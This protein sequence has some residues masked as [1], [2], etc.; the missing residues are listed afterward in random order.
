MVKMKCLVQKGCNFIA[1]AMD[2]HLL[3]L[4][5]WEYV[6]GSIASR[7]CVVHTYSGECD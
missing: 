5:P 4:I 7:V 6:S 2:L 3:A 1:H